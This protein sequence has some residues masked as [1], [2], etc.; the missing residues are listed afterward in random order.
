MLD[1]ALSALLA[2]VAGHYARLSPSDVGIGLTGGRLVVEDVELRPESLGSPALPFRIIKGRAG[3]LRINVPWAAL[4]SAPIVVHLENV[5][6]VAAPR[7]RSL[8]VSPPKPPPA[9]AHRWHE[10]R[11]GRVLYNVQLEILGLRVEYRDGDCVARVDAKELHINSADAAFRPSFAPLDAPGLGAVAMRKLLVVRALRCVMWPHKRGGESFETASP[12][13]DDVDVTVKALLCACEGAKDGTQTD[14]VHADVDVE[15]DDPSVNISK[16]QLDWIQHILEGASSSMPSEQTPP[17]SAE[18]PPRRTRS[19][20][21]PTNG[22]H[23]DVLE[24]DAE[25]SSPL[26]TALSPRVRSVSAPPLQTSI[27]AVGKETRRE[28]EDDASSQASLV[29]DEQSYELI[30]QDIITSKP[31][32]SSLR[33]LWNAIVAENSDETADDA[34]FALGLSSAN[35]ERRRTAEE[36]LQR[37]I[38]LAGVR[39]PDDDIDEE[40]EK[41]EQVHFAKKAVAMAAAAGGLTLR[42]RLRT[43]DARA[44]ASVKELEEQLR[45]ERMVREGLEDAEAALVEASERVKRAEEVANAMK[46]KNRSL[47]KELEELELMTARSGRNKD[48]VIRQTEAALTKAE[49]NLQELLREREAN[50]GLAAKEEPQTEGRRIVRSGTFVVVDGNSDDEIDDVDSDEEHFGENHKVDVLGDYGEGE[51][52]GVMNVG[53]RRLIAEMREEGDAEAVG[54]GDMGVKDVLTGDIRVAWEE[55][56]ELR[57][58][59]EQ[60][61][62]PPPQSRSKR[63]SFAEEGL[64]LI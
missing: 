64:T 26:P 36:R 24:K 13:L 55:E 32:Q 25:P 42:V 20:T 34:A 59:L 29:T 41:I 60:H 19:Y 30:P 18:R 12:L 37:R 35:T 45:G 16:R 62:S 15:L 4:S 31:K 27:D 28:Y 50:W 63:A 22:D 6:L 38:S 54:E 21:M 49:R 43:P 17:P 48:A 52:G 58:K 47:Q 46:E 3:S 51:M 14:G 53:E 7:S 11:L 39:Q 10:T 56:S 57:E 44:W 9:L 40:D 2:S 23:A 1:T 33:S 8:P 5:E 61:F